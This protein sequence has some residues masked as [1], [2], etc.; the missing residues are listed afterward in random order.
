MACGA[1]VVDMEFKSTFRHHGRVNRGEAT[2]GFGHVASSI[3]NHEATPPVNPPVDSTSPMS[4]GVVVETPSFWPCLDA[5]ATIVAC[6]SRQ[7]RRFKTV[8]P[9]PNSPI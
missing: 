9:R 6:L 5:R 1:A 4:S 7:E 8:H 2:L 3:A